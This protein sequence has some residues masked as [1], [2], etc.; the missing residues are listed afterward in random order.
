MRARL[1]Y[2]KFLET[3]DPLAD[4][5]IGGFIPNDVFDEFEE[6]AAKKWINLLK[7]TFEGKTVIGIMDM[8]E[9]R[10]GDWKE[11]TIKVKKVLN[12]YERDGFGYEISLRD[13]NGNNYT[14]LGNKKIYVTD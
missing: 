10:H 7:T 12:T 8:W 3:N 4:M 11:Y 5:R 13:E 1:V 2:E 9:G 6:E 14:V